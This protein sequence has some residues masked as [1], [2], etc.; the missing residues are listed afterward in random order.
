MFTPPAPS[1]AES[2]NNNNNEYYL[3]TAHS[4]SYLDGRG[5]ML[6]IEQLFEKMNELFLEYQNGNI[7]VEMRNNEY[8]KKNIISD[9]EVIT[10]L[11]NDIKTGVKTKQ[12]PKYNFAE[13]LP[14]DKHLSPSKRQISTLF[15]DFNY[16][17]KLKEK[18]REKKT[19]VHSL[20]VSIISHS[21]SNLY[22]LKSNTNI[23][24]EDKIFPLKLLIN[25]PVDLRQFIHN[26]NEPFEKI[27]NLVTV[28]SIPIIVYSNLESFNQLSK[29][30]E[31]IIWRSAIE[32]KTDLALCISSRDFINTQIRQIECL[33]DLSHS[34]FYTIAT[35]VINFD[36]EDEEDEE[37]ENCGRVSSLNISNLGELKYSMKEEIGVFKINKLYGGSGS[38]SWGDSLYVAIATS[39]HTTSI[40]FVYCD[41]YYNDTISLIADST[42][43]LLNHFAFTIM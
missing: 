1:Q 15:R 21:F 34:E 33:K 43:S 41:I 17:S 23:G 38:R 32:Y 35:P 22:N 12:T 4:H 11:L 40:S 19:S 24:E 20:I 36:E 18:C 2:P 39:S 9:D 30:S 28:P 16:Y 37:D 6:F 13:F 31:N 29:E 27:C 25:T 3:I 14:A 8:P 42:I 26:E 5:Y 10:N 7:N